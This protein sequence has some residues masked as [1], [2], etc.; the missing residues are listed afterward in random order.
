MAVLVLALGAIAVIALVII[1]EEYK[2]SEMTPQEREEYS[3]NVVLTYEWGSLNGEMICPH[4]RN[5]GQVRSKP[6]VRSKGISGSKA[7]AAMLTGGLSVFA[8][9]LSRKE[10]Q[11]QAHC[12]ACNNTWEF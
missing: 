1:C 10:N 4:C 3:R 12:C 11:T 2:L 7:T 5:K 6:V 9:G 8:T